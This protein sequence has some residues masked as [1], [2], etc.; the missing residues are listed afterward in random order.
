MENKG[1]PGDWRLCSGPESGKVDQGAIRPA[2]LGSSSGNPALGSLDG[3]LLTASSEKSTTN[4]HPHA[5]KHPAFT[6][7]CGGGPRSPRGL[8]T[9]RAKW[10]E[11]S[12]RNEEHDLTDQIFHH[13]HKSPSSKKPVLI[14][15]QRL[16]IS[17]LDTFEEKRMLLRSLGT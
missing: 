8:H 5:H 4:P 11:P 14:L 1:L 17:G 6:P 7:R 10:G 2:E 15:N 9:P 3:R 16:I 12:S 13:L